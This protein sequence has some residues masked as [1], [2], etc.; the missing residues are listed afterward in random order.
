[1]VSKDNKLWAFL[2]TLADGA[3]VVVFANTKRRVDMC[4]R[5]FQSFGSVSVSVTHTSLRREK[6]ILSLPLSLTFP[7]VFPFRFACLKKM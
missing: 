2:G 4:A 3:K 5:T 6:D 7:I 1:L